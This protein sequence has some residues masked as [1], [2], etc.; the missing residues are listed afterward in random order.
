MRRS[1]Q[2][3]ARVMVALARDCLSWCDTP[4]R[5]GHVHDWLDRR[6]PAPRGREIASPPGESADV[7]SAPD[8]RVRRR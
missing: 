2:M 6:P 7:V 8:R 1:A 5:G 4:L 3:I